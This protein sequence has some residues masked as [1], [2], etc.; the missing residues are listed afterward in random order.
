M[1]SLPGISLCGCGFSEASAINFATIHLC[2]GV[3]D[4][5]LGF[6]R[7]SANAAMHWSTSCF[8][9]VRI[10]FMILS[11]RSNGVLPPGS[12]PGGMT[13]VDCLGLL[14]C[15]VAFPAPDVSTL[16]GGELSVPDQMLI[17]KTSASYAGD[18]SRSDQRRRCRV[19]A[20][21]IGKLARPSTGKGGRVQR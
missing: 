13:N 20:R 5:R 3:F 6:L 21:Y 1:V 17:G 16:F 11:N 12:S 15:S 19:C 4:R 8:D 14:I 10:R 18:D 2:G 7:R 9:A